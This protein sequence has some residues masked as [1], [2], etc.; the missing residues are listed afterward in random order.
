MN[1]PKELVL[2]YAIWRSGGRCSFE[3]KHA[4]GDGDTQLLNY[5]GYMCCLGQFCEQAG[6]PRR[7]LEGRYYPEVL[8]NA[9]RLFVS[10]GYN[11]DL[12]NKAAGINDND[13]MSIAERVVELQ[14]LFKRHKKTITLK[15]F[16]TEI[17]KQ[18]EDLKK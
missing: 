10:R 7:A 13:A 15:N 12:T 6:V 3:N 18:I 17:L 9:P 11:S 4:L 1:L 16:P 2:D 14:K 8:S 5:Q